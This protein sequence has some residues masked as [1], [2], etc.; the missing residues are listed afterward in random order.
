MVPYWSC[1]LWYS[2][3]CHVPSALELLE[4]GIERVLSFG[5]AIHLHD[6][7]YNICSGS[8]IFLAGMASPSV[9][10]GPFCYPMRSSVSRLDLPVLWLAFLVFHC[11]LSSHCSHLLSILTLMHWAYSCGTS[12]S[13]PWL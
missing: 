1:L 7:H 5:V 10:R 2:S 8:L 9:T 4:T 3:C 11:F 13:E 12:T 6:S